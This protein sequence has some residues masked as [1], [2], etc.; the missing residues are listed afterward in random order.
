MATREDLKK[1]VL[2]ALDTVPEDVLEEVAAYLEHRQSGYGS[3]PPDEPPYK[4]VALGGLWE[5]F[6][7]SD[8]DVSDVRRE[9]WG[10]LADGSRE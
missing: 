2:T 8:E 5:G 1:R 6:R 10:R 4:P 7:I 3:Y 9:M